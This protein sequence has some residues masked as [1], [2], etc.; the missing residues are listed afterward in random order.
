MATKTKLAYVANKTLGPPYS[1][2][3]TFRQW[4]KK[5]IDKKVGF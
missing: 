2:W 4:S 1:I 3:Q 5:K